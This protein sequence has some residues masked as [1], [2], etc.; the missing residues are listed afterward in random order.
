MNVMVSL[1]F[2]GTAYHGSQIQRNANTVQAE[3]QRALYEVYQQKVDIKC[4]S[5]TDTGVHA[6]V[7]TVSFALG[8]CW[9]P[10]DLQRALNATLP[11]DIRVLD[12]KIVGEGFHARYDATGK[13]YLYLI[14]NGPVMDPFLN[15]RACFFPL[16]IDE[17]QLHEV[18]QVFVGRHDFKAFCGVKSRPDDTVR[19]I[20]DCSV[21]REGHLVTL[22]VTAD[23]FLYN[24]ARAIA[25][26]LLN[27]CRGRVARGQIEEWLASGLR[28]NLIATAP[29]CGLY[30]DEVFY[31]DGYGVAE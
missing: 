20:S 26:T 2:V 30:L 5:R 18:A 6:N 17:R 25:G 16:A 9:Q 28:D 31:A 13:R 21:S 1:R 22:S 19:T 29:A 23:G 14:W 11:Y 15:D 12:C 7:F 10:A 3:F 8:D 24:M 27:V 4:C